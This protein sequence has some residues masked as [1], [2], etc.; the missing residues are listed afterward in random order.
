[1]MQIQD[2]TPLSPT[3]RPTPAAFWIL[4]AIWLLLLGLAAGAAVGLTQIYRSDRI[5][6]GV[7]ALDVDLGGLT[8]AEAAERLDEAWQA[9]K[10]TLF[11]EDASWPLAPDQLGLRLDAGLMARQAH[12]LGR[13]PA[14]AAAMRDTISR[15]LAGLNILPV[16]AAA[17]PVEP[18]W[19][20]DRAAAAETVRTLAAQIEV[21]AQDA[22][23][24]VVDGKVTTRPSATGRALDIAAVLAALE[25]HPWQTAMAQLDAT[26]AR[27]IAAP[28]VFQ[29]PQITDV[30]AVVSE[31]SPLLGQPITLQLFDAVRNER[32]TWV[33]SPAD[34]GQWLAF[35]A[36]APSADAAAGKTL[37]WSVDEAQIIAYLKAQNQTLDNQ[38]YVDSR[39][40]APSLAAAFKARQAVVKL[41]LSHTDRAH[42][43]QSGETLSSIAF[44]YGMPYPWIQAANPG[45][46][47]AI[48]VGDR[49]RIPSPDVLLPLPAVDNKRIV[50][51]LSEQRVR[52]YANDRLQWNWPASTG[53][54]ESPTSPGVFQVQ[55]HEEL[56]YAANW[57]L[58]MP[59]F[60]G[61]YRPVP[62]NNFMNGFHGFPSRDRRQFLWESNLGGPIT[63]GCVLVS[64][65]NAKLLYDWAEVG[66]IV[67]IQR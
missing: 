20:F 52:V 36:P 51:S 50:V 8:V 24:Q 12:A 31:V 19:Y 38:R 47:D 37:T 59:W 3:R 42:T 55:S 44:D 32:L 22:G 21:P 67:E 28:I 53:M 2:D 58:Y 60:M 49:I 45:I 35:Q 14:T 4:L 6:A 56:A 63:Y 61:I 66:V 11:T 30:S 7:S 41:A 34:L 29:A 25:T 27:R 46:G 23:I 13:S 15:L 9:R 33:V 54:A 62:G 40:V 10:I 16:R 17:R 18:E 5:L 65:T 26:A 43:V 1:M 48:F 39:A 64:T 57:D